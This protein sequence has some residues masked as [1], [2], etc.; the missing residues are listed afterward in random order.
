MATMIRKQIYIESAQERRLKQL[1]AATGLTEAEI[2]RR[3]L[4]QQLLSL[5]ISQPNLSA[6]EQELAF[7]DSL[8]EQGPLPGRRSWRRDDLYD[9]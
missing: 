9:R 4:D 7:I 2:I 5:R 1:A 6:W 8:I 3:A